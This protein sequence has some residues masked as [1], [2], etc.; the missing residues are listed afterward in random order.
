M[1]YHDKSKAFTLAEGATQRIC[2]RTEQSEFVQ[3]SKTTLLRTA[4]NSRD[5]SLLDNFRKAA[6][7]L[8]EV[9]ITLGIIG[10]VAVLTLPN[11]IANY[12]KKVTVNRL[13]AAYSIFSQAVNHSVQD[14]GDISNWELSYSDMAP[15]YIFP[16][17][18]TNGTVKK[19]D[20]C[21]LG[22]DGSSYIHWGGWSD[23]GKIYSMKNG[24][25]YSLIYDHEVIYLTVDL[26][27][28]KGPNRMGRDGFVFEILP[29]NNTLILA[30]ANKTIADIKNNFFGGCKKF[31]NTAYYS[32][33]FCGALIMVDGWDIKDYYPW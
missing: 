31:S 8:A 33:A 9:L 10:I 28:K 5:V 11:I 4:H 16:Y 32:G 18:E 29:S 23:N 17:V 30:G 3:V 27:G 12:E 6:F 7:T 14:N 19:Y 25:T 13:K 21:N 26:N 15:K 2:A 22:T 20:L 24:M 1:A